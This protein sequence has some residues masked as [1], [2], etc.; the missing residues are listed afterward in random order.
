MSNGPVNGARRSDNRGIAEGRAPRFLA[1]VVNWILPMSWSANET[2]E[3]VL[4]EHSGPTRY[5]LEVSWVKN[6]GPFRLT[7]TYPTRSPGALS[8]LPKC[9]NLRH[10]P[11]NMP[12]LGMV[13]FAL[14]LDFHVDHGWRD[15]C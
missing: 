5:E 14:S 7:R 9:L 15:M 2:T 1:P 10:V 4:R 6:N 12:E 13:Q 11:G 3:V 8:A